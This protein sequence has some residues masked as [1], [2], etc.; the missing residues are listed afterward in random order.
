M[1]KWIKELVPKM[2]NW[3][4]TGLTQVEYTQKTVLFF[5]H[6]CLQTHSLVTRL[7]TS[8]LHLDQI[9]ISAVTILRAFNSKLQLRIWLEAFPSCSAQAWLT[10]C[11]LAYGKGR[12]AL[13]FMSHSINSSAPSPTALLLLSGI[14]LGP[15]EEGLGGRR[16]K[17]SMC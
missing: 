9:S 17:C 5:S 11:R 14:R 15:W 1:D 2:R 6:R 13:Y 7:P 3:F 12:L 10:T 8:G 16:A 4:M